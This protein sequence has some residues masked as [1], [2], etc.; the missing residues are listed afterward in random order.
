MGLQLEGSLQGIMNKKTYIAPT[1]E[2]TEIETVAMLAA[3]IIGIDTNHGG[4][5]EQLSN[6]RRGTWG[7]LWAEE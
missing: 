1:V 6:D 7:N 3:S 4:S 2:I 5:D